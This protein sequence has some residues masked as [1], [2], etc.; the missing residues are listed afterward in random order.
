MLVA[1]LWEDP[2]FG[3][4]S[5][6]DLEATCYV[7]GAL[8]GSEKLDLANDQLRLEVPTIKQFNK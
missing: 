2:M 4:I 5:V 8:I 6:F 3:E 1:L 7:I